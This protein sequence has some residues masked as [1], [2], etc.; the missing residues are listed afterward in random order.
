MA[1]VSKKLRRAFV[2]GMETIGSTATGIA[3]SARYKVD[4]MNMINTRK[5]LLS[6][7]AAEAYTLW[8]QGT[9]MPDEVAELLREISEIDRQLDVMRAE[10]IESVKPAQPQYTS[11]DA[12][13]TTMD[14]A[15]SEASA[16][17][18]LIGNMSSIGQAIDDFTRE[19]ME[20]PGSV[21]PTAVAPHDDASPKEQEAEH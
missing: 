5:E 6:K 8:Q 9:P 11:T 16:V 15:P 10:Y 3:N 7:V 4:E 19:L 20:S 18:E 14:K 1:E 12:D 17:E 13:E 21:D 2:R